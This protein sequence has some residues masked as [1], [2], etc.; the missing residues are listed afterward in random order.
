VV[1]Y[2][3]LVAL[4]QLTFVRTERTPSANDA[5]TGEILPNS[6]FLQAPPRPLRLELSTNRA[7]GLG[8]SNTGINNAKVAKDQPLLKDIRLHR[9]VYFCV[10]AAL[11]FFTIS[12][13]HLPREPEPARHLIDP[14]SSG[15]TLSSGYIHHPG[16]ECKPWPCNRTG[17]AKPSAS[18]TLGLPMLDCKCRGFD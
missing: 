10:L 6:P 2:R 8:R 16:S 9:R 11:I 1:F 3:R 4:S 7:S 12:T 17:N 18:R 15:A 14:D 13:S 5:S